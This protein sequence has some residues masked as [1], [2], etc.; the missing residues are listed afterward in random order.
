MFAIFRVPEAS[1][2][3]L[4]R[5]ASRVALIL[6]GTGDETQETSYPSQDYPVIHRIS[7]K[8]KGNVLPE[9]NCTIVSFLL[10]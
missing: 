5:T 9:I 3:F 4:G 8:A 2:A 6:R 1:G 7:L 10:T